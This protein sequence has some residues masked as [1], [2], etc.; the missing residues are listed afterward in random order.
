MLIRLTTI[1]KSSEVIELIIDK[2]NKK[3]LI[4]LSMA[5]WTYIRI[6]MSIQ[7]GLR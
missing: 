3:L 6:K 5:S 1:I 2:T 7:L 4:E